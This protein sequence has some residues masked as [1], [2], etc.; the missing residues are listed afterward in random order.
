MR[1]TIYIYIFFLTSAQSI[2]VPIIICNKYNDRHLTIQ[3]LWNTFYLRLLLQ[4]FVSWVA[5]F[6]LLI[7]ES[8]ATCM[9][10]YLVNFSFYK[11]GRRSISR[12][13]HCISVCSKFNL[14]CFPS[15]KQSVS[16]S[17]SSKYLYVSFLIFCT[18]DFVFTAQP[19][20]FLFSSLLELFYPFNWLDW[21]LWQMIWAWSIKELVRGQSTIMMSI[22]AGKLEWNY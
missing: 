3:L 2:W 14:S 8:N 15:L 6:Y 18:F 11:F 9:Y 1:L 4:R 16:S 10:P 7:R 19:C 17:A 20:T 21:L 12:G 5:S 13:R 22:W